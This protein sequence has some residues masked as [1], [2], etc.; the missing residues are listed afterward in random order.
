VILLLAGCEKFVEVGLPD[1]RISS[2]V[3]F[4]NDETAI[5]AANSMYN[6]LLLGNG[7]LGGTVSNITLMAA[8]SADEVADY[9]NIE[10]YSTFYTNTLS[11][12]NDYVLRLW[13]AAYNTIYE[14]NAVREGVTQS[15]A[16][17]DEVKAQLE[18]EA[19]FIRALCHFYLVNLFEAVPVVTTTDYRVNASA[20]RNPV[21]EVYDQITE[22][23]LAAR[24]LL[25]AG[26]SAGDRLRPSS[27]AA[28]AM[29]AR[30]YL[31]RENYAAAEAEAT[32]VIGQ[33]AYVLEEDV[34][35]I[36]LVASDEAI[37]QLSQVKP[38]NF[39]TGDAWLF[40]IWSDYFQNALSGEL[41]A[42]FEAGDA[43]ST[44]WINA[45]TTEAGDTYYHAYK[46]KEYLAVDNTSF[47][48]SL[49]V[50]RLAEQYLIRA[51]A[52]A[53]Q[54]KLAEAIEDLDRIR[55]RAGL[56]LVA[57]ENPGIGKEALISAI[58]HERRIE[59][60]CELGHRWFDLKR[61]DTVDEVLS[62]V[63]PGWTSNAVLYPL[64]EAELMS[65]PY[66]RPQNGGY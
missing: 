65:N 64:P 49:A 2:A 10:V 36:F 58:M 4:T 19:L 47:T 3:V 24:A 26:Q 17:S 25:E 32:A 66:L 34:A 28:T 31:Y 20:V 60:F 46:Y 14:A 55:V 5:A 1:T 39:P 41:L 48:E 38:S 63:K 62:T 15:S 9:S 53:R 21:D 8:M 50:L 29:L 30:V 22:D 16:L 61:T 56:P 57:D 33:A 45:W 27:D 43:R 11:A 52:R 13:N 54:D 6:S 23:L 40:V 18:G 7:I 35:E 37:W 12:D 42:D 44:A 51:E 59:L